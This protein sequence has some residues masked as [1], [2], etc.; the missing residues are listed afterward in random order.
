M[1]TEPDLVKIGDNAC[2]DDASLIA[3]INSKGQFSLN[4]L[5]VGDNC[6]MRY[7]T[8][9]L[10]G[11]SMEKGSIMLEHTLILSGEVLDENT[12]WQGWPG[13]IVGRK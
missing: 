11:A 5:S 12:V 7:G 13:R 3:H 8:R 10:S 4:P 6:T 2:I 9:L 1:M